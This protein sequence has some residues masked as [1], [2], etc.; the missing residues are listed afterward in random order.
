MK[1]KYQSMQEL[2]IAPYGVSIL[3]TGGEER[4][5]PV[6]TGIA[7]ADAR[8]A[9]DTLEAPDTYDERIELGKK[10]CKKS[11]SR[12]SKSKAKELGIAFHALMKAPRLLPN[13]TTGYKFLILCL[14]ATVADLVVGK[15]PGTPIVV[16][17]GLTTIPLALRSI[18]DCFVPF[19][20]LKGD[21]KIIRPSCLEAVVP[22][23]AVQ[24]SND[25]IDY[26]G[27]WLKPHGD[28]QPAWLPLFAV[29]VAIAPNVPD[30]VVKKI[31]ASSPLAMPII[32]GH[33]S[34]SRSSRPVV[35]LPGKDFRSYSP[36]TVK[37]INKHM[38]LIRAQLFGFTRYIR[39]SEERR[40]KL[41]D[42]MSKYYPMA[43]A[44]KYVTTLDEH[45]EVAIWAAG[46][47]AFETLL[48]YASD[49][50]RKWL[51]KEEANQYL[52]EAW[53][54]VLPESSPEPPSPESASI[55]VRWDSLP[56]FW[57]F[58]REYLEHYR[59]HIAARDTKC[60]ADTVAAVR[61]TKGEDHLVFP[62]AQLTKSYTDYVHAHDGSVPEGNLY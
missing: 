53:A 52:L 2:Y 15:L 3:L 28:K 40:E 12:L 54:A 16:L 1:K 9:F 42:R 33:R 21:G 60:V 59:D 62:R 8:A 11:G 24:P 56:V 47:A 5:D 58:V 37:K 61:V 45:P 30:D 7:H 19:K 25:I 22:I 51:S 27:G 10:Q 49:K 48:V 38:P 43:H 29:P 44:G 35:N 34:I 26:I 32:C 13:H 55:S 50:K 14:L 46:L 17:E 20:K 4:L 31:L 41:L 18:V 6:G 23:W 36:K 57:T 39:K